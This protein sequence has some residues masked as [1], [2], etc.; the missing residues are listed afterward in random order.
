MD[1]KPILLVKLPE[2][3]FSMEQ[4]VYMKKNLKAEC[5]D[6]NI[7]IVSGEK[8]H[9]EVLNGEAVVNYELDEQDQ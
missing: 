3:D 6:Y 4:I 1:A 8:V 2:G 5:P 9:V 7:V